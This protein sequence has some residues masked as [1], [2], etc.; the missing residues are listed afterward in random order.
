MVHIML[1]LSERKLRV[2]VRVFLRP[3]FQAVKPLYLTYWN[4]FYKARPIFF[5]QSPP[6][7]DKFTKLYISLNLIIDGKQP[8]KKIIEMSLKMTLGF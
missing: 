8:F 6:P 1:F 3:N 7:M 4:E 5:S 2:S